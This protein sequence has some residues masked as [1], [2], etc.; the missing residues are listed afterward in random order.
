[1]RLR[2]RFEAY[3][4]TSADMEND[5]DIPALLLVINGHQHTLHVV[6]ETL[7]RPQPVLVIADSGGAAADI[8]RFMATRAL[9]TQGG[10]GRTAEYIRAAEVRHA[11]MH[12]YPCLHSAMRFCARACVCMCRCIPCTTLTCTCTPLLCTTLTATSAHRAIAR[13]QVLLPQILLM[14]RRLGGNGE[15]RLVL[16]ESGELALSQNEA[17]LEVSGARTAY[18]LHACA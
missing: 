9:P 13:S 4:A 1:M 3:V 14:G 10:D 16:V 8:A 17:S 18:L 7:K 12:A 11:R 5:V 15:P 2:D 6:L